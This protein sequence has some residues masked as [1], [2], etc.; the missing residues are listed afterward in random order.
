[1]KPQTA[2]VSVIIPMKDSEDFIQ[3]AIHSIWAQSLKAQ[4]I[5][6]VDDGSSDGSIGCVKKMM[7][8]GSIPILLLEGP[9]KGPG[10]ARNV[11][12]TNSSGEF[13]AFLDSDDLWPPLKLERQMARF[14]K[15]P[16]VDVVAGFVQYFQKQM[17]NELAPDPETVIEEIYHVHLGASIYRRSAF[18]LIGL[19]DQSFVYSEDVD[20]ILRVRESSLAMSILNHITL[21][22]RRHDNSMTSKFSTQE[23]R[24]FNRALMLSLMR[25]KRKGY[26]G[27][28]PPFKELVDY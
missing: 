20:L 18:D 4:E 17:E 14:A 1:M 5:V 2:P 12:I 8:T 21:Y 16:H 10:P 13:I 15:E 24:D 25:R 3:D 11:G 23:K 22:Y 28:L 9:G 7:G 19:F 26:K 27:N 6:V